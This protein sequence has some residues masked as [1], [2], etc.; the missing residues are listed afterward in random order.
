MRCTDGVKDDESDGDCGK[1]PPET[2]ICNSAAGCS[3]KGCE[4]PMM[5]TGASG[6]TSSSTGGEP[7]SGAA[8]KRASRVAARRPFFVLR[9]HRAQE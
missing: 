7:T 8:K 1:C 2:K 9:S 3:L 5:M 4:F 6:A